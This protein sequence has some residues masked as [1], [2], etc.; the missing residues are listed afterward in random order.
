MVSKELL[1]IIYMPL[2]YRNGFS[3]VTWLIYV[4]AT[5]DSYV[6]S[7]QL[8]WYNRNQRRK[9][10]FCFRFF[11]HMV[12][13]VGYHFITLVHH[14]YNASFTCLYFLY[15]RYDLFIRALVS[16]EE[17]HRHFFIYQRDRS[18]LHFCSRVALSMYV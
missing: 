4:T 17:Y 13:Q 1:Y 8:K 7:Q 10:F 6:V 16:S 2:F 12:G 9:Y 11:Y 5:E 3:Q 18:M 15:V 14:G